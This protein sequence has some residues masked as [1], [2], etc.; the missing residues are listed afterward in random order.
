MDLLSEDY[1]NDIPNKGTFYK[2]GA[3]HSW[4]TC[5]KKLTSEWMNVNT[6]YIKTFVDH[7]QYPK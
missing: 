3:I 7:E 6:K 5:I 1:K 4:Y 2:K